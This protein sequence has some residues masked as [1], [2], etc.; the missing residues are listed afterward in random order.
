MLWLYVFE[1]LDAH[2]LLK[3]LQVCKLWYDLITTCTRKLDFGNRPSTTAVVQQFLRFFHRAH[4]T[5]LHLNTCNKQTVLLLEEQLPS[6]RHLTVRRRYRPFRVYTFRELPRL[7]QLQSLHLTPH[8]VWHP[9]NQLYCSCSLYLSKKTLNFIGGCMPELKVLSLPHCLTLHDWHLYN[10][11]QL[12]ELNVKA[13]RYISD[14][15]LQQL[16]QLRVL[17]VLDCPLVTGRFLSWLPQLQQLSA[18]PKITTQCSKRDALLRCE[19][20]QG[21]GRHL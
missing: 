20:R 8:T 9:P 21:Q 17:N 6:L 12:Q 7:T 11:T 4:I 15:G 19:A 3:A 14:Q 5:E 1:K 2:T 18:D 13:C 10:L 16:T